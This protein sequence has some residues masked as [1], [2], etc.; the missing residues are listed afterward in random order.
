MMTY[1]NLLFVSRNPC[2]SGQCFAIEFGQETLKDLGSQS[3]FSWTV[4]C[5]WKVTIIG[6]TYQSSRNPCFR[7][8]CFAIYDLHNFFIMSYESQ[9]LF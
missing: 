1:L 5:N 9:S 3:L 4:F 7:G 6:T 8:Q 2:F